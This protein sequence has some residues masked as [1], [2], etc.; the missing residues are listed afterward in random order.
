MEGVESPIPEI[1]DYYLKNIFP[2]MLPK[3]SSDFI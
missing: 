1:K 3:T 2:N